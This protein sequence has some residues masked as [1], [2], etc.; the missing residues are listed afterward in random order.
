MVVVVVAV[1][2]G[3]VVVGVIIV[4][5]TVEALVVTVVVVLVVVVAVVVV[6]VVVVVSIMAGAV[7]PVRKT[8]IFSGLAQLG[9][10]SLCHTYH[11]R[12]TKKHG[13]R[14]AQQ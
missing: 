8:F 11:Q 13:R 3:I 9:N 12:L 7:S 6:V 2:E 14:G 4:E 1:V 10:T 5:V